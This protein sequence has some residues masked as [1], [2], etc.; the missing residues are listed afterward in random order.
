[1]L[2]PPAD[3]Y[4]VWP[5]GMRARF[6]PAEGVM[7]GI[8]GEK[9]FAI[10]RH[11]LRGRDP[12]DGDYRI[13]T[14]GGSTTECLYLD[15][16]E[17]WANRLE[18]ALAARGRPTWVGNAGVS[19]HTSREHLLTARHLVPQEQPDA[20]V[21]LAGINDFMLRLEQGDDYDAAAMQSPIVQQSLM[22][23]AFRDHPRRDA[24]ARA[25][26]DLAVVRLV[27][28]WRR[29]SATDKPPAEIVQDRCGLFM[30]DRRLHRQQ[31]PPLTELPPLTAALAEFRANL[32]A[33]ATVARR[34][35]A[36]VVLVTQPFLWQEDMPKELAD[37]LL[38]GEAP[39]GYY[40]PAAMIDGLEQYNAVTRAIARELDLELVDLTDRLPKDTAAFV[41][42]VHFNENGARLVAAA[43]AAH[44][45]ARTPYR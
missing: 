7:P 33:L 36:R 26:Q 2:L 42:D 9:R 32:E 25:W 12:A 35:G 11:G 13:L 43:I 21:V 22:E 15:Q 1:A 31:A 16:E 29:A 45:A 37:L 39:Y 3:L 4:C 30:V 10:N 34:G 5:P 18:V 40:V 28:R 27:Q 38:F 14:I 24:D 8:S 19:G 23:R 20:V 41:D 44:F 6:Q 17:T